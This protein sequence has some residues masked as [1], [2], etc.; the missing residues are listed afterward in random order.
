MGGWPDLPVPACC[1]RFGASI[2]GVARLPYIFRPR[3][4]TAMGWPRPSRHS[5]FPNRPWAR[6][7]RSRGHRDDGLP[8]ISCQAA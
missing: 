1:R 3:R 5:Q 4:Q 6:A 2:Q 7:R 8:D